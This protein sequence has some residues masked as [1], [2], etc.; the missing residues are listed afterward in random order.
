L[1]EQFGFSLISSASIGLMTIARDDVRYS[2]QNYIRRIDRSLTGPS[3]RVIGIYGPPHA[4]LQAK[5][6]DGSWSAAMHSA[7]SGV[8]DPDQM[9]IRSLSSS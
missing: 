4:E 1:P 9:D 6:E 8:S 2:V 5:N 3:I 7:F